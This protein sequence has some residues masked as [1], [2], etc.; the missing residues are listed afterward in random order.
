[1]TTE[2]LYYEDPSMEFESR[3]IS[4]SGK[5]IILERTAFYPEGGG[6]P[7]DRGLLFIG[8]EAYHVVDVR[9][10]EEEIVHTLD[11]EPP[12]HE[13]RVR[14]RVDADVRLLHSRAHT[15]LHILNAVVYREMNRARV[16]G[17]QIDSDHKARMD[18]NLPA[19]CSNED[20]RALQP[21]IDTWV[22]K[23]LPVTIRRVS[24]TEAMATP[25]MIRTE[26][27]SVPADSEGMVR[28]VDIGGLDRQACGGTHVGNTR[29]CGRIVITKV[30]SKGQNNRRVSIACL[31]A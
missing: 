26:N 30:K 3:I 18:F 22:K 28:I 15:A 20:V 2:K 8:G 17:A 13:R 9:Q 14:G 27:R 25:G 19:A 4:L 5:A 11:R 31:A 12:A 10:R 16:T 7:P 29:E 1:M 21:I 6:Q 23:G 24:R